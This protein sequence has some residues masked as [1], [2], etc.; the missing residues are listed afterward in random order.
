MET[1]SPH[2]TENPPG[3]NIDTVHY[4]IPERDFEKLQA[5]VIAHGIALSDVLTAAFHAAQHL[6]QNSGSQNDAGNGSASMHHDVIEVLQNTSFLD[7]AKQVCRAADVAGDLQAKHT[8]V[9]PQGFSRTLPEARQASDTLP[10]HVS[11]G[12][13]LH[14]QAGKSEMRSPEGEIQCHVYQSQ[15]RLSGTM[16]FS[17]D[18][19]TSDAVR[20]IA[21]NLQSL[22]SLALDSPAVPILALPLGDAKPRREPLSVEPVDYPRDASIVELFRQ[23][24][25]STPAA[26]AVRKGDEAQITYSQLDEQSDRLA[27]GLRKRQLVAET[28]ITV[29]APRS[30]ETIVAFVG[31]LKAN[32]AYLPLDINAPHGRIRSTL[33]TV[34]SGPKLMLVGGMVEPPSVDGFEVVRIAHLISENGREPGIQSEQPSAT[35]LA[36]IMSTSGS[37]GAPKG[38]M[39]EH[40]GVVRLVKNGTA[41][42]QLPPAPRVAHLSNI[43]FDASTWEIFASLL[44]GGV[45]ICIDYDTVIDASALAKVFRHEEIQA[46]VLSPALL[47]N[48]VEYPEMFDSVEVLLSGGDRLDVTTAIAVRSLVSTFY[49]VYGPTENTCLSTV[50]RIQ[51]EDTFPNGVPIGRAISNS[52]A[53]VVDDNLR[54][55]VAGTVGE[56]VVTGDGLARGYTDP[57]LDEGRFPEIRVDGRQV[58]AYRTGDRVRLCPREAQLEFL[59][60]M[61][62]QQVKIRGN[63]VEIAEVERTLLDC[64]DIVRDAAVIV[65]NNSTG[66]GADI[67]LVAFV[68]IR[69]ALSSHGEQALLAHRPPQ[70]DRSQL[71]VVILQRLQDKLPSYMIPTSVIILDHMPLN[72][73]GKVDRQELAKQAGKSGDTKLKVPHASPRNSL[74]T[75]LCAIFDEVFGLEGV[76]VSDGFFDLG[77]HSLTATKLAAR[78]Y[79]KL[80]WKPSVKDVFNYPVVADLAQRLIAEPSNYQPIPSIAHRDEP[81]ELSFAQGRMWFLEQLRPGAYVIATATR[82]HGELQLTALAEALLALEARHESLRTVYYHREGIAMQAVRAFEQRELK[83]VQVTSQNSLQSL[84]HEE[85]GRRFH[86]DEEPGWRSTVFSCGPD[87]HVISLVMHHIVADG[88]SVNILCEELSTLYSA[89]LRGDDLSAQLP[90][91]SLCYRDF[92]AWHRQQPQTP[93]YQRQLEYWTTQLD[94]SRPAELVC[95]RSRSSTPSGDE[96]GLVQF[97]IQDALYR[98]M[99][100]FAAAN[101]VTPFMLTLAAFRAAHYRLT[102]SRDATIGAPVANR[103]R[104]ELEPL[105][106]FFVNTQCLRTFVD[107]TTTFRTLVEHVRDTTA[108]AMANQDVPFEHLVSELC[109][110]SRDTSKNP[111]VQIM[112]ALHS[113]ERLGEIQVEGLVTEPI[114]A[115]PRTRLDLEVHLYQQVGERLTGHAIFSKDLFESASVHCVVAVFQDMLAAGLDSPATPISNL[116]LT[117]RSEELKKCDQHSL[118]SS[119]IPE[120]HY[121]ASIVDLFA[122][123]VASDPGAIAITDASGQVTYAELNQQSDSLASAL[124]HHHQLAPET[125]VGI[126]GPR[127][128]ETIVTML[129]ILK[130]GLAYL[131]LDIHVPPARTANILSSIPGRTLVIASDTV[132]LPSLEA[133]SVQFVRF[134]DAVRASRMEKASNTDRSLLPLPTSLAYVVFTSGSTGKPKGVLIEHRSVVRLAKRGGTSVTQLPARARIAHL[135]NIA[136]DASTWEVY[137]ALLNGGTVVCIEYAD[138]LDTHRLGRVFARERIQ[139]AMFISPVHKACIT[140]CPDGL[141]TVEVLHIGGEIIPMGLV[142]KAKA[143]LRCVI[144]NVYGPTENTCL[145]T[146]YTITDQDL[147]AGNI[148]IGFSIDGSGVCIMDENQQ[149]VP[150]GVL[151]EIVV[152]GSGVARGY[153][154][155]SLNQGRF[156]EV[157]INGAPVRG[158]RTGDW[159]RLRPYDGAVEFFGRMDSELKIRGYRVATGEIENTMLC[160][161]RVSDAA[162]VSRELGDSGPELVA[163]ATVQS[164]LPRGSGGV[165]DEGCPPDHDATTDLE[166]RIWQ[167]LQAQLPSYMVPVS[168]KVLARMPVTANG[169]LDRRELERQARA[170]VGRRSLKRA[171]VAP[172]TDVEAV[173]CTTFA[174]VLGLNNVGIEDNFF[175]IGGHSLLAMRIVARLD[176]RL[177][178]L[179]TSVKD[180]FDHPIVKDL[181]RTLSPVSKPYTSIPRLDAGSNTPFEL[182][183]AQGRLWFLEQLHAQEARNSITL[184]VHIRGGLQIQALHTAILVLEHRHEAL[185]TTFQ[186]FNGIVAQTVAPYSP[187]ALEVVHVAASRLHNVLF[188]EQARPFDLAAGPAWRPILFRSENGDHVL[189]IVV[190]HIVSD[191]WSIDIL[192]REL[193]S[194]YS[195]AVR[196]LDPWAWLEPLP[197]RYRDFAAWQRQD[198]QQIS[199]HQTQLEYWM[200]QLQ[201]NQP[202]EL[203]H[204]RPRESAPVGHADLVP[205]KLEKA[206]CENLERCAVTYSVTPFVVLLAAFRVAHYRIT[207]SRDA[208]IGSP[209]A[210]RNVQELEGIVGLFVNTLCLRLRVDDDTSFNELLLQTGRVVGEAF[211]NQDVPFEQIVSKLPGS[212]DALRNP[213]VQILFALHSQEQLGTLQIDGLTTEPMSTRPTTRLDLELHLHHSRGQLNGSVLFSTDIFDIATIRTLTKIFQEV[214]AR[215]IESPFESIIDLPLSPAVAEPCE[216]D[217]LNIGPS[218]SEGS[219][220]DVFR[221]QVTSKPHHIA[222]EDASTQLTY[223]E[224]DVHS[225]LIAR[226]LEQRGYAAETIVGVFAPRSCETIV[227]FMGILKA[228]LAYLPFDVNAPA[229]RNE[230]ILSS[231]PGRKL[232]LVGA[233]VQSPPTGMPDVELVR[234][235]DMTAAQTDDPRRHRAMHPHPASLAYVMFTSGSTGKPK[236]VMAEHRNVVQRAFSSERLPTSVRVAHLSTLTFDSTTWEVYTALLNGGTVVCIDY[237]AVVDLVRFGQVV[238]DKAVEAAMITP[239]FLN[240]CLSFCPT[241]LKCFQVLHVIGDNFPPKNAALASR[242]VSGSLY[243]SYGPTENTILSTSHRIREQTYVKRVPIGRPIRDSGAYVMD[244]KQRLVPSGVLGELVLTGEGVARGYLDPALDLDRFV[245]IRPV[246]GGDWIRAYRTGDMARLR[247]TDGQIDFIGRTDQQVKIRGY[248][249]ELAEVEHAILSCDFVT[250][251][252]VLPRDAGELGLELFGF[253]TA[254]QH[255]GAVHAGEQ[256]STERMRGLEVAIRQRLQ[257]RLPSYMVPVWVAVLPKLPLNANGKVDRALLQVQAQQIQHRP[258][259]SADD[260]FRTRAEATVCSVFADILQSRDIGPT[261]NFFNI[262]GHSLLAMRVVAR[263]NKELNVEASVRDIFDYPVLR[264]LSRRL[265]PGSAPYVA[266]PRIDEHDDSDTCELSFAQAGIWFMEQLRQ[267]ETGYTIPLAVRFHGRL[268]L[269]ALNVAL[270]ALEERHEALRTTFKQ[271]D[272]EVVQTVRPF[273]THSLRVVSVPSHSLQDVLSKEQAYS[274]DLSNEPGWRPT[275]F[276]CTDNDS[277]HILSI[278]MHHIV[279]DGWSIDVLCRELGTLYSAALT[280]ISQ[281]LQ[282]QLRPLTIRYRD[283]ARWQRLRAQEASQQQQLEY[284]QKQL[285]DS[286]PAEL[287]CDF[288]RPPMLSGQAGSVAFSLDGETYENLKRFASAHDVTPFVV[289]LAAFRATH[290]RLTGSQDANIGIPTAAGRSRQEL[291]RLIGIFVNTLCIRLVADEDLSFKDLVQQTRQTVTDALL[292]QDVP[293]ERLVSSLRPHGRHASRNPI[294]QLLFALHSQERLGEIQLEG[295]AAEPLSTQPTTRLDLEIHLYQKEQALEGAAVFSRDLF[296]ATTVQNVVD[297]FQELLGYAMKHP[298]NAVAD[299]PLSSGSIGPLYREHEDYPRDSSI[300][301]IFRTQ[302][303]L[304]PDA[305]A[306]RQVSSSTSLSYAQ[307]DQQSDCVSSWLCQQDF[308]SESIIGVYAPRSLEAIIAFLGVLKA[309][310]AYLPFDVHAPTARTE[311]VLLSATGLKLILLGASFEFP[312][313]P[314]GGVRTEHVAGILSAVKHEGTVSVERP[315][316][317]PGASNLAYVMFT[318][319]S[320]GMPK[321]VL[322]EHRG[323][324]RL[325]RSGNV[326]EQFPNA[327]RMAHLANLAFDAS[328]W[329]IY[330]ALLRGGTVVCVDQ[331]ILLDSDALEHTLVS[332][333]VQAA[334]M[335]PSLLRHLSQNHFRAIRTLDVLHIAGERLDG[336]LATAVGR[337]IPASVH[338]AYGPTENSIASTVFDISRTDSF[339][340]GVPIGHAVSFSGA[341]VMDR[342]Q[343]TVPTGV[344]GELVVV[345][346]GIARG[347]T[348]PRLNHDRFVEVCIDG[349]VQRAYRTGDRARRRPKDAELEFLGRLDQQVKVRGYRVE[350]AEVEQGLLACEGVNDAAVVAQ[351]STDGGTELIAFVTALTLNTEHNSKTARSIRQRLRMELPSY[352]VPKWVRIL[353]RMP[354]NTSGKTDRQELARQALIPHSG[355]EGSQIESVPPRTQAEAVLCSTLATLLGLGAAEVGVTD[356]FFDLGGDSLMATKL[357]ARLNSQLNTDL[358]IKEVFDCPTLEDLARK[359]IHDGVSYTQISSI[360]HQ[361][362]VPLSFAQGRLWFLGQLRPGD[363]SYNIPLGAKLTGSLH[364]GALEQALFWL[365]LRHETLRTVF[366]TTDGAAMQVVLPPSRR[367]LRIVDV[368]GS[369]E[370]AFVQEQA[371]PFDLT[372]EPGF[373][374]A[375]FRTGTGNEYVLS[376]IMHHII[377]DGWSVDVLCRDLANLY[378]AALRGSAE[379]A[380]PLRPLHVQYRDFA[381]WQRQESTTPEYQRQLDYWTE[382]LK[383]SKPAELL[384]DHLRPAVRS[385]RASV[386]EFVIEGQRYEK[387][388][389]CASAYDAT[390][391]IV[392]LTIFRATH[393]RLTGA[394]DATFGFPIANRTRYELEEIVGCF[395]SLLQHARDSATK[396]YANQDVPFENVVAELQ[397][398]FRDASRNPLVQLVFAF[399]PQEKLGNIHLEG[400]ASE[401]MPGQPTTRMDLEFHVFQADNKLMGVVMYSTELFER[402]TILGMVDV[403]QELLDQSIRAPKDPIADL[404]ITTGISNLKQNGLLTIHRSDYPQDL[405]IVDLFC[406]QASTTPEA[407]AVRQG[408]VQLT[409]TQLDRESDSLAAAL[410]RRRLPAE[411]LIGVYAPRSCETIIVFLAI[412]KARLAY[413]PLDIHAPL[414]RTESIMDCIPGQ[415]LVIVGHALPKPACKLDNVEMAHVAEIKEGLVQGPSTQDPSTQSASEHDPLP[416]TPR[417]ADLAYVIFTSG[418]TGKPKGVMLEHRGVVRLARNTALMSHLPQNP[419]LAHLTNISFDASIFEIYCALL[420]GGTVICIEHERVLSPKA[421]HEFEQGEVDGSLLTPALLRLILE[422]NPV[423]VSRLRGLWVAGEAFPVKDACRAEALLPGGVFNAY[424]PTENTVLSAVFAV[425]HNQA[426]PN[427]MPIGRAISSSGTYVLD[428]QQRPVPVGVLGELVVTGDGVARGYTDSTLNRG[429]FCEVVIDGQRTRAYLTGD[430]VRHRHDGELEFFGRIDQQVNIRSHRVEIGEVEH[431]ILSCDMVADVAVVTR[432]INDLDKQLVG[433]V[434]TT[435]RDGPSASYVESQVRDWSLHFDQSTFANLDGISASDLGRD[436]VGWKSMIDGKCI[437]RAEMED[438]LQDTICTLL[439]GKPPNHVLE[440]GSGTGMVLFN[441]GYGL[442][443]Y[444]GVEPSAEAATF[445]C[446]RAQ[447]LPGLAGKVEIRVGSAMDVRSMDGLCPS[448]VVMNSVVQY[449]PSKEYLLD[450]LATLLPLPGLERVFIGDV[451]PRTLNEELMATRALHNLGDKVRRGDLLHEVTRLLE[452]E[453][454]LLIDPSFFT[455]LHRQFPTLIAHVEILPKKM[456]ACNEL[457]S[458]RYAAVLHVGSAA[459]LNVRSIGEDSW[460]DFSVFAL[461]PDDLSL[462]LQ[463]SVDRPFIAIGNVPNSMT[464]FGQCLLEQ[465]RQPSHSAD[466]AAW[467]TNVDQ[468]W[469]SRQALTPHDVVRMGEQAGFQAELSWARQASGRGKFDVVFHRFASPTNSRVYMRFPVDPPNLMSVSSPLQRKEHE[470]ISYF[471]KQKLQAELPSYMIPTSITVLDRLPINSSGKVDRQELKRRTQASL[472][473]RMGTRYMPPMGDIQIKLCEAFA[474]VLGIERIGATDNFFDLGGHSLMAT[475]LVARLN[476]RLNVQLSVKDIFDFPVLRDLAQ[477]VTPGSV[478]YEAV[479]PIKQRD[480]VVELSFAQ[481][482]VWFLEQLRPGT[483]WYSVPLATR[484]DGLVQLAALEDALESLKQRHETL[485]TTFQQQ[486]GVAV[487]VVHPYV[488]GTLRVMDV[489]SAGGAREALREEQTRSFDLTKEPGFRPVVFRSGDQYVLAITM[490]HI[491]SDGWSMQILCRDLATLYSAALRG[492]DLSGQLQPLSVQYRDYAVWQRQESQEAEHRRQFEYWNR[493]LQD[494]R[495]AEFLHDYSRP[496]AMSSKAGVVEFTLAIPTRPQLSQFGTGAGS[497]VTPFMVLLAAFRAAHYRLTGS[498]DAVIGTPI[499]NRNRQELEPIIG[500]FVNTQC[501]RLSIDEGQTSFYDLVQHTRRIATDAFANQDVPFEQIVASRMQSEAR[502]P[503]RNPLVQIMFALHTEEKLGQLQL[504]NLPATPMPIEPTTRMDLEL[505]VYQAQTA[506]ECAILFST[507][508]FSEPTVQTIATVFQ[509]LLAHG[510][511]SP[512]T[513]ISDVPLTGRH[514][515]Y[516]PPEEDLSQSSRPSYPRD[517]SIVELF[518]QQA[519]STPATVAVKDISRSLTYRELDAA[520]DRVANNLCARGL[521]TEALVGVYAAR[522][523]ETIV[524]FLGILKAGLAYLPLD[525][526]APDERTHSILSTVSGCRIVLVGKETRVPSIQLE[527]L[528]FVNTADLISQSSDPAPTVPLPS[529]TSLAYVMFTSGSTGKPKGV[530]I[531]HR[532]VVRLVKHGSIELPLEPRVAHL[533]NTAFDASTWE[534]YTAL[535][536]GGTLVC[537]DQDTVVD[538]H[539]LAATMVREGIHAAV[540][541]PALLQSCIAECAHMFGSVQVLLSGGDRLDPATATKAS[542]LVERF[543]NVYGPTENT[544]LSTIYRVPEGSEDFPNGVPIGRAIHNSASYVMDQQQKEVHCGVVG[545]LVVSGDGLARGYTDSA[546]DKQR[547]VE[548]LVAGQR[549]RAYRTGDRVRCRPADGELEFLGRMDRQV[550]IRGHRV[551]IAEVEAA[552]LRCQDIVAD[553]VV[554]SR[555]SDSSGSELNA[556]ITSPSTVSRSPADELHKTRLIAAIE[557]RLNAQLPVYMLPRSIRILDNMPLNPNG[558]V[559]VQALKAL[560]HEPE[561]ESPKVRTAPRSPMEKAI[562]KAFAD[563]LGMGEETVG[564]TDN[565]FGLGGHSILVT[566]LAA[567]IKRHL[568]LIVSVKELFEHSVV[569]DLAAYLT[570]SNP[571]PWEQAVA[572]LSP[573]RAFQLLPGHESTTIQNELAAKLSIEG[574]QIVDAYPVT[575]VQ[576]HHIRDPRTGYL[577]P[578]FPFLLDLPSGVPVDKLQ[579][580]CQLLVERHDI[581]RTVFVPLA[582]TM[583]QV[584]L[585]NIEFAVDVFE[586]RQ[587]L[588]TAASA[589]LDG[590][591]S[592]PLRLG[593][594]F[595][596]LTIIMNEDTHTRLLLRISHALYDGLSFQHVS[597]TLHGLMTGADL[598]PATGFSCYMQHMVESRFK[599]YEYWRNLLHGS[600]MTTLQ[601]TD[602][603]GYHVG[604]VDD[605]SMATRVVPVVRPENTAVVTQATVFTAACALMLAGE[606]GLSDVLFGRAVSGRQGLPIEY[607]SVVGPCVNTFPVRV[608]IKPDCDLMEI[609]KQVQQQYVEGMPYQTLGFDDIKAN[610]TAWSD[611]VPNFWC[612]TAYHDFPTGGV[613]LQQSRHP[614]PPPVHDL[615]LGAVV[616]PDGTQVELSVQANPAYLDSRAVERMLSRLCELLDALGQAQGQKLEEG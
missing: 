100:H 337:A 560:A 245:K 462:F 515:E 591:A 461:N 198:P 541:T 85:Q 132:S 55:V 565:F 77:G 114:P 9:Y 600:M 263:L 464:G 135:S 297:V 7:L 171:Y 442:Q 225:D 389:Q 143:S 376:L 242:L 416:S 603:K 489:S 363:T 34:V 555:D 19:V 542:D 247:P 149:I 126:Y 531:E 317:R 128:H 119:R 97:S 151:G 444:M 239:G 424:G 59:G 49:N 81:I 550:K 595:F 127:S 578:R 380:T 3:R 373:R 362:A 267:G 51:S 558:K 552:L 257:A 38:V 503:S 265:V 193:A 319:G 195:A 434:T 168:I 353:D 395:E 176:K 105:V 490:H 223:A 455:D 527:A 218:K 306:V 540:M 590:D 545:E 332:E 613:R 355:D 615:E 429:R 33:S 405:S 581:F 103:N 155:T 25:A 364:L 173:L 437:P 219:I 554:I 358:S 233:T 347:Y 357:I 145:S 164:A 472:A 39:I 411:T 593:Q 234:I 589:V 410:R 80:G 408:P 312:A 157:P 482:R 118:V 57:S 582:T 544:C 421:L 454:E 251:A 10:R 117:N 211:A 152:T 301:D 42:S 616:Y 430:R 180:L 294:V 23:Q 476:R 150:L 549:I 419:R 390:L 101:R 382:E 125:L 36:Y 204:D 82:V 566:R 291:D 236:G 439:D 577:R 83:V 505:H 575:Q 264:D 252:A 191:G 78:I 26:I 22:L 187:R 12:L 401:P 475:R 240:Q 368:K 440:I 139:A 183:F 504:A 428:R 509:E 181:A 56:L 302:A 201:D 432:D 21:S 40:R 514:G 456:R 493:Q 287:I 349:E 418:S 8:L 113:Q 535:L 524:A 50:Y 29:Y 76:G 66:G 588:D 277:M 447:S 133:D 360:Q 35:S 320:T 47:Q 614:R 498:T 551:E 210:N 406:G 144:N 409:Y 67:E 200:Q 111:L 351:Q 372:Q 102:R 528:D 407:I 557:Q 74:E 538:T 186:S 121:D 431:A 339:T 73:N 94:G 369:L 396:A 508:L 280:D 525:V 160:C 208:T 532:G 574:A 61:D 238:R 413:L 58:R 122:E 602:T 285:A 520:S 518:R 458:Y 228:G 278:V 609:L 361:E 441:L 179:K 2:E 383:D 571:R 154:E 394:L 342:N 116:A 325:F 108:N 386:V 48:C 159:G 340:N 598:L 573:Y 415:K 310:H 220:V 250:D 446:E 327:V 96:A 88:W 501:I 161:D 296:E 31:I 604:A 427:G 546:L 217:V 594:P 375:V 371:R 5:F 381:V 466:E 286:Q 324:V 597:E 300:V 259:E 213:L 4:E 112:F 562:C 350:L 91:L 314:S 539:N 388:R 496:P 224:L 601:D 473:K 214:L 402:P 276:Q 262:G 465:A 484:F 330:A 299:L 321:G 303:A 580:C 423:A 261:D 450:V 249:V 346:D 309:G 438:W 543:Y 487:Q 537:I 185:R 194:V 561:A 79:R 235:A 445:L 70:P 260:A 153:T 433:Y 333:R 163:F 584:V 478:L 222:V 13:H 289:L 468:L 471:I 281:D 370:D 271:T 62:G 93:E 420:N 197:L 316:P 412:L 255:D 172:R 374:P 75:T 206:L 341:Y 140:E 513:C 443:S 564:T 414:A 607:Q 158:Y 295:L 522:S 521:A 579:Q 37:T 494:S 241:A 500:F 585:N 587:D 84:L 311:A 344:L 268:Q 136:F 115:T 354:I 435:A 162:V 188:E 14:K 305:T 44:N 359:L 86:L 221:E 526:N 397:P 512:A 292:N 92:V 166:H 391:F 523:C 87:H 379:I 53:Y 15:G 425:D 611:T 104:Q 451:R 398:E 146:L 109:S 459:S 559:D 20:T 298:T 24:V 517:A 336:T 452:Q 453:E 436:F 216:R 189:S 491:V 338:N 486:D 207:G 530:M 313:A 182:S 90:A 449:F 385:G 307:L 403:F 148:P 293:F 258:M 17:P 202:A 134:G 137:G 69:S 568:G 569:A 322:V 237:A 356:N 470:E 463:R 270:L 387:L 393:Y 576:L 196:G 138:T 256:G 308:P 283:Y 422:E 460:I 129:G 203:E 95:D 52:G 167:Y 326:A 99:M 448:L 192:S 274:F 43:A 318:S 329:E 174:E 417:A 282:T 290:F 1:P 273:C 315:L 328:S 480:R 71:I 46:A 110:G 16:V 547:F 492:E 510:Y 275:V 335:T 248:R 65:R 98:N 142:A 378:S 272:E 215:A 89:A 516:R 288:P 610:C 612:A 64:D 534:V 469:R 156:L 511:A 177:G 279:C 483:T 488:R 232:V 165:V 141:Q 384:Y 467:L 230:S 572:N 107:D 570:T 426:F 529:A 120:P 41:V 6:S 506:F 124:R 45:L 606:S 608:Q 184:A 253:A 366:R 60:R 536:N 331:T 583:Y 502:D 63:R 507:D 485:R 254:G 209:V 479:T 130:A 243:N 190:H 567:H 592:H 246:D 457:S 175:E 54:L 147:H 323:I 227:A 556:F 343:R 212:R 477:K 170:A 304:A 72:T 586:T 599:G 68:T 269:E 495:P 27:A 244:R 178:G 123:Q 199:K 226:S 348:D 474:E 169:K 400:L 284:W 30:C 499:A 32:L 497:A 229:A 334:T 352:M 131:P 205:F 377:S 11:I 367:G 481:S 553:A 345:G 404:P 266:I 399:H 106:G 596:R 231:V 563:V 28:P 18:L 519:G 365:T 392:L 605:F 548:V 533:S